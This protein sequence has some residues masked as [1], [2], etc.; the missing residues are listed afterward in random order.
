[1]LWRR[2]EKF[3][4]K[5]HYNTYKS[6]VMSAGTRIGFD[7]FGSSQEHNRVRTTHVESLPKG[8]DWVPALLWMLTLHMP[9]HSVNPSAA[10]ANVCG[11]MIQHAYRSYK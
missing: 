1:M 9:V 7:V 5:F 3:G 10:A 8:P 2:G 11:F 4:R 6:L